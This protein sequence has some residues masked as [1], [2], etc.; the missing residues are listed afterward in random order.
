MHNRIIQSQLLSFLICKHQET[1]ASSGTKLASCNKKRCRFHLGSKTAHFLPG[2]PFVEQL[3]TNWHCFR[4]MLSVKSVFALD[5]TCMTGKSFFFRSC[6]KGVCHVQISYCRILYGGIFPAGSLHTDG[7]C[8]NYDIS[9][10]YLRLHTAAGSNAD[11]SICAAPG[12][13]F[14][15]NG[16]RRSADSGGCHADFH[17]VQGSC[18]CDIFSVVCNENRVVKILG[19]FHTPFRVS[20]HDYVAANF[21]LCNLDM[22]LPAGIFRI[23]FHSVT[24]VLYRTEYLPP[25]A[26]WNSW[27]QTPE[28]SGK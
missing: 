15:G 10:F 6:H 9:A 18:I 24:S 11:K 4:L 28:R 17:A 23:V 12:K 3:I 21:P 26:L 25:S 16:G 7:T 2:L 1:G 5:N 14:H 27:I 20:R 22:I 8:G 13:L 19:N